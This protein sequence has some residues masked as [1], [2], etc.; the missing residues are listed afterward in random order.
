MLLYVTS[1]VH[2]KLIYSLL[3]CYITITKV[4]RS[5]AEAMNFC[6][7]PGIDQWLGELL[8]DPRGA[9]FAKRLLLQDGFLDGWT[10]DLL[11]FRCKNIPSC[12]MSWTSHQKKTVVCFSAFVFREIVPWNFMIPMVVST[13]ISP[14][15]KAGGLSPSQPSYTPF[16]VQSL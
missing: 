5:T 14:C 1:L 12:Y 13:F 3:G 8:N 9:G 4:A 6:A 10:A 7:T 2:I 11:L 16:N 15:W